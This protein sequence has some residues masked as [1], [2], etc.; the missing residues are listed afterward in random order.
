M[1][2]ILSIVLVTLLFFLKNTKI[3]FIIFFGV[4]GLISFILSIPKE[5]KE[6]WMYDAIALFIVILT[7]LTLS[8]GSK[9]IMRVILLSNPNGFKY[10][11][12]MRKAYLAFSLIAAVFAAYMFFIKG[13]IY[14]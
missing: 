1:L 9:I 2:F 12:I 14:D 6:S 3:L 10:E 7:Y 11:N 8:I 13:V 5:S 4:F